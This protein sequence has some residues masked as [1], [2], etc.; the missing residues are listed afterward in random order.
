[1]FKTRLK[2]I[3][4]KHAFPKQKQSPDSRSRLL[5]NY[6][7]LYVKENNKL[8]VKRIILLCK[9]GGLLINKRY[10]YYDIVAVSNEVELKE[11]HR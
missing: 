1:M 5:K 6:F 4:E 2:E 10:S 8:A 3:H 9:P 7:P 11:I